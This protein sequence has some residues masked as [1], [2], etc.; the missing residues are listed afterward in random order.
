MNSPTLRRAFTGLAGAVLVLA[1]SLSAGAAT[2]ASITLTPSSGP[3]TTRTQ[4]DG[5]GFGSSET[6]SLSIAG[7]TVG[8]AQTDPSGAFVTR[9]TIPG[10]A[11]PGAATV[12][13]TGQGGATGSADFLVRTNWTQFRFDQDHTGVNP[14]ENVL[15]VGNVPRMQLDWQAQLGKPVFGS[16]P[17]VVDGVAYVGSS[18]G[19]LWAID[20]NGCGQSLCTTPLWTGFGGPQILDSPTVVNGVVYVGSQTSPTSND[21]RLS[22]YDAHGCGQSQCAP[23]WQGNA[24]P[25]SILDSSPAVA[26]GVVFVGAF[27]GKLYAFDANGCGQALCDPLWVGPTGGSIESSPTV[28]HGVVFIGSDDGKLYAFDAN[29]CGQASCRPLWRGN[30]GAF[31]IFNSSPAVA[32][33]KVYIAAQHTLAAFNAAGC[34]SSSCAPLWTGS[35]QQEFFGGS[36]ALYKGRVYIGLESDLG[37]FDANGC[38]QAQCGPLWLGFGAGSQAQVSSSPAVANGVVFVGRNTAEVLAFPAAGCGAFVC[39][40]LWSGSTKDQV[41]DSSPAVVD[42]KLYI[43]S[44]D[45]NFPEDISGRLYVFDLPG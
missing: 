9:I 27:D 4:V 11:R 39:D 8:S 45:N 18:D 3:P 43:G 13:A 23:L 40:E 34:G 41:V 26:N 12:T 25:Q 38:G 42:G 24:G 44:A 7:H 16:S 5:T 1:S 6:V 35:F 37:V 17:T 20:A 14:F 2:A 10:S 29:G 19:T 30:V 31:G 36:P 21:G 33:G 28:S 22:A 15:T 32:K